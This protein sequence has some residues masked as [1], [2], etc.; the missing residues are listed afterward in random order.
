MR[1][2]TLKEVQAKDR[3]QQ[4]GMN[5]LQNVIFPIRTDTYMDSNCICVMYIPFC[6][7]ATSQSAWR[8]G[9]W[10]CGRQP[11]PT[12]KAPARCAVFVAYGAAD[13]D[14]DRHTCKF[15]NKSKTISLL[16]Q[17]SWWTGCIL[18]W[19]AGRPHW[20]WLW[21]CVAYLPGNLVDLLPWENLSR[22][23]LIRIS[24]G[25]LSATGLE[26]SQLRSF[27][28]KNIRFHA[29]VGLT[30]FPPYVSPLKPWATRSRYH[31]AMEQ[32]LERLKHQEL[33]PGMTHPLMLLR[34]VPKKIRMILGMT[35]DHCDI[36]TSWWLKSYG[37]CN[38]MIGF[39]LLP[40]CP[41]KL[42]WHQIWYAKKL[43]MSFLLFG[44]V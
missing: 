8:L 39:S 19:I 12:A 23:W 28:K 11:K 20:V 44:I 43:F 40:T 36:L 31:S 3:M 32:L 18:H 15:G 24:F 2:L 27:P 14:A 38:L 37:M 25:D 5:E 33:D 34:R 4:K 42:P 7:H 35:G 1:A 41:Q 29:R 30:V 22:L 13:D 17:I 10:E 6:W 16:V 21:P 26:V 9:A